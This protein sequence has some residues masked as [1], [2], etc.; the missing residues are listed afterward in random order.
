VRAI[1]KVIAVLSIL[2]GGAF[3]AVEFSG[4]TLGAMLRTYDL[5]S[6]IR[7]IGRRSDA[8]VRISTDLVA[9]QVGGAALARTIRQSRWQALS[10]RTFPVPQNIR[11]DLEPHFP[12][13]DFDTLRWKPANGRL[14]L[15]TALTQWYLKEGAIALEDLIVFSS[16]STAKGRS[17]WAHELTHVVQYQELGI[18]GFARTY[19]LD[20]ARLE[21]QAR[22][23]AFVVMSKVNKRGPNE[24]SSR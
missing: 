17:L 24:L 13:I 3:I 10:E 4:H 11:D 5:K 23:N 20:H 8:Q 21:L 14:S 18:N 2:I 16:L 9:R 19:V 7:A 1:F 15:G 6:D 22:Q 12:T